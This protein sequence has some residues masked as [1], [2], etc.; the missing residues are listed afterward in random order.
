MGQ[1]PDQAGPR[2][3]TRT[4]A[5]AGT[6]QRAALSPDRGRARPAPSQGHGARSKWGEARGAV[7]RRVPLPCKQKAALAAAL[8]CLVLLGRPLLCL[9]PA[10]SPRLP[11][12]ESPPLPGPPPAPRPH[13]AFPATRFF[14]A[15][16]P[17]CASEDHSPSRLGIV[18]VLLLS[19]L[20]AKHLMGLVT[21][22][23]PEA[24]STEPVQ[25][26]VEYTLFE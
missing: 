22:A 10:P 12:L 3:P 6:E 8:P 15:L 4:T 24:V 18:A 23:S 20:T 7:G 2:L 1:E 5:P 26:R 14:P 13:R 25:S 19:Y 21:Q 16:A 9:P 11:L 17:S